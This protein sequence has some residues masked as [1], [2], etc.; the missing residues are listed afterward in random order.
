MI[1]FDISFHNKILSGNFPL[2]IDLICSF[3]FII[4][5]ADSFSKNFDKK[6]KKEILIN[7]KT[8]NTFNIF[9]NL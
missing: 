6:N 5:S 2:L 4:I 8:K 7:I 1:C 9:K 3:E